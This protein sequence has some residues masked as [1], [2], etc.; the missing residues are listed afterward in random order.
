VGRARSLGTLAVALAAVL[1][2]AAG[3][4]AARPYVGTPCGRTPGLLCSNVSVPLDRSGVFPGSVTLH[5]ELLPPNGVSR[6]TIFLIAGGPG[7]GSARSFDLGTPSNAS[8]F[9]Y[10][11]PG[12]TLVAYDDR[13]TGDSGLI[14]CPALQVATDIDQEAQ[15]AAD[16]ASTIGPQRAF[17]G[18]ADHAEDLE[19]VR[20]LIGIDKVALY[21]VSYGTKLALAYALAHPD[22]VERLVLDSVLPPDQPDP[23]QA[24]VLRDIPATLNTFCAGLCAVT[25]DFAG[26]VVAVANA[27]AAKPAHGTVLQ[28][29]G[30]AKA[31]KLDGASMVGIVIDSDLNPGLAAEL[32]AAVHAA[33]SGNVQPL[34]R[35]YDLDNQESQLSSAELSF[36]LYAATSCRDGAFPWTPDTP[37][38]SRPALFTQAV[39]ALPAGAFG[40]FGSWAAKLGNADFCLDWPSP[41]GGEALGAGPLPNVPVLAIS[42]G[43]DMRTPTENATAVLS[44]FP[45]GRL[46]TVPGVGH[47]ALLADPS[48]CALNAVRTWILGGTPPDSCPRKPSFIEPLGAFPAGKTTGKEGPAA[49]YSIAAKT[50]REAEAAWFLASNDGS[51]GTV[52]GIYSGRLVQT[53]SRT[54]KLVGY[55]IAPGVTVSGSLRQTSTGPPLAFEGLLTVGGRSAAQ[56]SLGLV[57]G[58][59]RG[60]LGGKR[61]GG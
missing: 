41:S 21:G 23:Y 48:G 34:L 35:L 15:L 3:P 39:A 22:H 9:Q 61:V 32:P 10:L 7:Q 40:P 30:R 20:Q 58:S 18:T 12:Y 60:T 45:Q 47:S 33:R 24:N 51:S 56:G 49:T 52:A 19:A 59:L 13:G 16:C 4:V 14:D 44:H 25:H 8:L 37:V 43:F 2:L 38:A 29:N 46:L 11:F 36:G 31:E 42:G 28:A 55:S 27:L 54:F 5:V 17:Y 6:G 50:V 53:G 57:D 26:D 1:T